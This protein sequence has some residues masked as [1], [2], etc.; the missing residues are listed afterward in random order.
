MLWY[1]VTSWILSFVGSTEWGDEIPKPVRQTD[2]DS[3]SEAELE[4]EKF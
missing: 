1:P 2:K 3:D 4:D